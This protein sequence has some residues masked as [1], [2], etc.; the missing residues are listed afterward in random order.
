VRRHYRIFY[1]DCLLSIFIQLTLYKNEE[2]WHHFIKCGSTVIHL[3]ASNVQNRKHKQITKQIISRKLDIYITSDQFFPFDNSKYKKW[4]IRNRFYLNMS[5]ITR[6][7]SYFEVLTTSTQ[8]GFCIT[9][10]TSKLQNKSLVESWIYIYIYMKLV[11][12]LK[13]FLQSILI[14][15]FQHICSIIYVYI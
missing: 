5:R 12:V 7:F 13:Y 10:N 15:P 8:Q 6:L 14:S 1:T 9:E 3:L 11:F 4:F 2:N